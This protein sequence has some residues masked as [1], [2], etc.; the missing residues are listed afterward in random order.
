VSGSGP[1]PARVELGDGAWL[2][3]W[4]EFLRGKR[5]Q[6]AELVGELPLRA[7]TF[8]LFGRTVAVPRLVAWIG[9]PDC[10]YRYSGQTYEPTPWTP[11]LARLRM[12]LAERIGLPWNAVLVNYYR[13]GRDSVGW[14]A[15]DERELG[16]G[17]DDVAIASLSFGSARRFVMRHRATGERREWTLGDG[18]LLVMRGRTQRLW[19]HAL[20]KTAA[21]VGPRLNLSFRVVGAKGEPDQASGG[22]GGGSPTGGG[23]IEER[24][25]RARGGP[26]ES[27]S[28][29]ESGSGTR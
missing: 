25:R 27:A 20:P 16:P 15:D 18:S 2:D 29:A 28:R 3:W 11:L 19:R 24:D 8:S 22:G 26:E 6:L 5:P 4:P 9:D 17:P 7:D 23:G 14:H 21:P 13:D 12:A 10:R 1:A